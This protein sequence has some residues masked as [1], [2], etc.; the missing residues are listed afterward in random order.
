MEEAGDVGEEGAVV[1]GPALG[2]QIATSPR[3]SPSLARSRAFVSARPQETR[4]GQSGGWQRVT[5]SG[6]IMNRAFGE[7]VYSSRNQEEEQTL[8][9]EEGASVRGPVQ[10][11]VRA[12]PD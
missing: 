4:Q 11:G 9:W 6:K 12:Q 5:E 3:K 10:A 1:V 2:S 8:R 7:S